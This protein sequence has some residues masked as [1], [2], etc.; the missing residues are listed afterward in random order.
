MDLAAWESASRKKGHQ[1]FKVYPR[2]FCGPLQCT[3]LAMR[4]S[5]LQPAKV[6]GAD[7]R[8]PKVSYTFMIL[9]LT[10]HGIS[11]NIA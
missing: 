6:S 7:S 10:Y 5:P 2:S 8:L 9:S 11:E 1:L 4:L 3:L